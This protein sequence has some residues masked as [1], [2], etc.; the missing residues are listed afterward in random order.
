MVPLNRKYLSDVPI[1]VKQ[2]LSGCDEEWA[3]HRKVIPITVQKDTVSKIVPKG[4]GYGYV[5]VE[6][7]GSDASSG[8]RGGKDVDSVIGYAHVI[9]GTIIVCSDDLGV[10]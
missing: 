4:S 9:E 8:K 10:G 1:Y 3:S 7:L 5:T 2:A 6:W